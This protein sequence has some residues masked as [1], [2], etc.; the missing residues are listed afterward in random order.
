MRAP[1]L[2]A[3]LLAGGAAILVLAAGFG[4][5]VA[6]A[7]HGTPAAAAAA[8]LVAAA[9][10][11]VWWFGRLRARRRGSRLE[12]GL[13][14]AAP[15]GDDD[16][17]V[18]QRDEALRR[19]RESRLW[20]AHGRAALYALPWYVVIGEPA[21]GKS[22]AVLAA[23]LGIT[24]GDGGGVRG[25]GGTRH[26]DWFFGTEAIVLDT[27]GRY[28][29]Q[30]QDR[31]EWLGF[32]ALLRRT[33][34]RAP[35]DGVVVAASID[36]LAA[37]TADT[38]IELA[39]S[40]RSRVHELTEQ[41]GV[42][43]PVYLLFTKADLI[44]GF[45]DFFADA[46]G[47]E[48]ERVWGA[49]LSCRDS[50]EGAARRFELAFAELR[51]GLR[52]RALMRL[53]SSCASASPATL[54]FG[55]EFAAL[56]PALATFVATLFDD[57]PYQLR[58]MLRGFYFS[59]ALQA[60]EARPRATEVAARRFSLPPAAPA[61][62]PA[63][64][65]ASRAFFLGQ[66]FA[67]VLGGDRGLVRR[68]LSPRRRHLQHAGYALALS[69]LAAT[70]GAF[71]LAY[72]ESGRL[73]SQT[74][75]EMGQI[76]ALQDGRDDLGSRLEALERLQRRLDALA[77]RPDTARWSARLGLDPGASLEERLLADYHAGVRDLMLVPVGTALERDLDAFVRAPGAPGTAQEQQ[78]VYDTLK[79][80]LMLGEPGRREAAHLNEQIARHWRGWL[81][82]RRGTL[83]ADELLRRARTV[84]AFALARAGDA[85]FPRLEARSALVEA[86][87]SRLR[88]ARDA[89]APEERVYD[90]IRTRAA[91]RHAPLTLAVVLGDDTPPGTLGSSTLVSGAYTREAW[92]ET[93]A[94]SMRAAAEGTL[95]HRDW[96][97]ETSSRED[98]TLRASPQR[99]KQTLADQHRQ[100]H[101]AA[102]Q[103]FADG[104]TLAP[105]RD[106]DDAI[107]ALE[108][109]CDPVVS[110]LRRLVIGMARH[111]ALDEPG[112]DL[113]V[114]A[115]AGTWGVWMRSAWGR[116]A[117]AAAA[118][119]AAGADTTG[120][121]ATLDLQAFAGLRAA[122]D[123]QAPL[124]RYLQALARVRSRL[125]AIA[126]QGEPGAGARELL[127]GTLADAEGS[128]IAA[129]LRL[130]EELLAQASPSARSLLRPLLAR[131][132]AA[133]VAV[134]VPVTE[135]ELNRRWANEVHD[136]FVRGPGAKYP[137]QPT[138][139]VEASAD[140]I[141]R[142]FGP[143]GSLARFAET[144][145]GPL[146][147]RHGDVLEPRRWGE[148]G[149]RLRPE[150]ARGLPLWLAAGAG[151][152]GP[153]AESTAFQLQPLAS[154]GLVEYSVDIDGQALR[155]RNA[156][157][158]WTDFVWPNPSGRS[159]VHIR[160]T[161]ADGTTISFVEAPGTFGLDRAFELAQRTRQADGG[162]ELAWSRDGHRLRVLLRVV[163]APDGAAVAATWRGLRL[164]AV[165]AGTSAAAATTGGGK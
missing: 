137:F 145:L 78:A 122:G 73:L 35:V 15:G 115:G 38:I 162:V 135:A 87:R 136:G 63:G 100:Q 11:A 139:R 36:Q 62:A 10:I 19:L 143:G 130:T 106:L 150:L 159:G 53:E 42:A 44:A 161:T 9:A 7:G 101:A 152:A 61:E 20:Q 81:E 75:T 134:L 116:S 45:E 83:A 126:R 158:G 124:Q 34:P 49:T 146:V 72:L 54:G 18:Q 25:V 157:A 147:V 110:P 85:A 149:I 93:V 52:E 67:R 70:L 102:W 8:A 160:G 59:S 141:A 79:T 148:L 37:Q 91:A 71:S 1:R 50:A 3:A 131:P 128:E 64:G 55:L 6:S 108:P 155:Y 76:S 138:A 117:P 104:V 97:L 29:V 165:V 154:A 57:N 21:A 58:P 22:S 46:D 89:R 74:V 164:P 77:Q 51:A 84:A 151:G 39:R 12:Q 114:A 123:A 48:R 56:E 142:V 99:L 132:L 40:L 5:A 111:S 24:P 30:P 103:Q 140:E 163:R 94:P 120:G 13:S 28:A 125:Q 31:G 129:A 90:E 80:Y 119:A 26:C 109:L 23:G 4:S 88:E 33:R 60:G 65:H 68:Q 86:V 41:L 16:A 96:V 153:G 47:D 118:S 2:R 92:L 105:F 32:L 133:S 121:R 95:Q 43:M 127:A 112:P 98:L 14:A 107:T 156:A 27:A 113:S 66:V 144:A 82:A 17:L 69:A